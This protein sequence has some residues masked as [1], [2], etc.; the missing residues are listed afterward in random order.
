MRS[1]LALVLVLVL[2]ASSLG[3][4][5]AL[6][7]GGP[8]APG[9]VS[10][11]LS[12][13]TGSLGGKQVELLLPVPPGA[14]TSA[15]RNITGGAGWY[16]LPGA[17]IDYQ[18]GPNASGSAHVQ[19]VGL[20]GLPV[21]VTVQ[22]TITFELRRVTA[23]GTESRIAN[24]SAEVPVFIA[25][26]A[27]V[28]NVTQV[29]WTTALNNATLAPGETVALNIS[30]TS[31]VPLG[32]LVVLYDGTSHPSAL[33]FALTPIPK[34]Q[35]QLSANPA[36]KEGAPGSSPV[37][38]V[39]VANLADQPDTVKLNATGTPGDWQI[40]LSAFQATI[41]A[42]GSTIV[43]VTVTIPPATPDGTRHTTT[44]TAQSSLGGAPN[45][46]PL[47]TTART[48]TACTVGGQLDTDCDGATD[49]DER[50][51]GSDPNLRTSTP[52]TT[53]SDGDG[54]SNKAEIDA[55]CDPFDRNDVPLAQGGCGPP[56]QSGGGGGAGGATGG[57][58]LGALGDAIAQALNVD[59]A[60][61]DL[62]ALV[63][64]L[65]FLLI[66]VL[67]I[68]LLLA[69]YPVKIALVE[70]RAVTEPGRGADYTVE[71]RSR[72]RRAQV[73]DLEVAELPQD[74][75]ARMNNPRVSLEPKGSQTVGVLIRPPEN[76]P[77][78]SK[79]EFQVRARS[80]LKPRS[81]ARAIAKL[82]IQ[83]R[84][85]GVA[86]PVEEAVPEPAFEPRAAPVE[87]EG[88]VYVP[89]SPALAGPFRV[90]IGDVRHD[91]PQPEQG[92]EVNT[93]ARIANDGTTRERVRVVLVVNG[94]VRDDVM[95][96]LEPGESAEAEF[97]WIAYL[98]RNEV[99]VIA[100]RS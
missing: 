2:A 67:L 31:T 36:S 34:G 43:L 85:A 65:L 37:Y 70:P 46:L 64:I 68:V 20:A 82:L 76:W 81:F 11:Y 14:A 44:F 55:G 93:T 91:P 84:P 86:L 66:L 30:G 22:N 62:I 74:W 28:S 45:T 87:P 56:G 39:T 9:A 24:T 89:P 49:F 54:A 19:I 60:T 78:P 6:A 69:R 48:T 13:S 35:L 47:T 57:R 94:K 27:P 77:A 96:E 92:G 3:L 4:E 25:P 16:A 58:P 98:L 26:G 90:R 88:P 95:S 75:D 5:A 29:N 53:D 100:E 61:G 1:R 17:P 38:A 63:L 73:V 79:R 83:P 50:K 21:G 12:R 71:L 15:V 72:T 7:Q 23:D 52:D 33:N 42:H 8:L 51:Y 32:G 80:R 97:H 18:F 59:S 41:Q 99:K 40:R 10:L